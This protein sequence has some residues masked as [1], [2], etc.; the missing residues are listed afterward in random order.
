M[1]VLRFYADLTQDEIAETLG[2]P[3]GT[4]KS[5]PPDVPIWARSS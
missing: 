3:V 5:G 4:V 2:V 1:V